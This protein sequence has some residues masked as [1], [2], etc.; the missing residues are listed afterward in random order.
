MPVK[1]LDDEFETVQPLV[2]C[3]AY[4]DPRAP[5]QNFSRQIQALKLTWL[6]CI[7]LTPSKVSISPPV[8]QTVACDHAA[9]Q[10]EQPYGT[11]RKSNTQ[12]E[13]IGYCCSAVR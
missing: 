10:T 8:G 4:C 7:R 9:G 2:V 11:W 13:P 12:S 5:Q 1:L 6:D 3:M